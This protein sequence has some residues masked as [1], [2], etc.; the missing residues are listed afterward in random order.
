MVK[1]NFR[2]NKD[3]ELPAWGNLRR[4]VHLRSTGFCEF[5]AK[6][7]GVNQ[8]FEVH[9]RWY[10]PIDSENNLMVVH[11]VC[12]RA[13]HFGGKINAMK[14]SLASQGDHGVNQTEAWIN[15]LKATESKKKK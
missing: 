4:Q 15:Y 11:R 1:L 14:G 2:S 10:P 12:H 3:R 7:L 9:H 6:P 13:I 8:Y 5:C